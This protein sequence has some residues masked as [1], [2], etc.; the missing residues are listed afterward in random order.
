MNAIGSFLWSVSGHLFKRNRTPYNF[1]REA[2]L[3]ILF[4]LTLKGTGF[5]NKAA[6]WIR[7]WLNDGMNVRPA[8]G[9]QSDDYLKKNSTKKPACYMLSLTKFTTSL[10]GWQWT[11]INYINWL[12]N[13]MIFHLDRGALQW[14]R[15]S[16]IRPWE[17]SSP[18]ILVSRFLW[19]CLTIQKVS[20]ALSIAVGIMQAIVISMTNA[21]AVGNSLKRQIFQTI[22]R[23][24]RQSA[25]NLTFRRAGW[26][27][28]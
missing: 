21:S 9:K 3:W 10:F 26:Y 18:T 27:I 14:P 22:P 8:A 17:S 24:C 6:V 23:C 1:M 19:Y 5:V 15:Q 7:V 4:S 2:L 25:C 28:R 12:Q 13:L 16:R 11:I 20:T